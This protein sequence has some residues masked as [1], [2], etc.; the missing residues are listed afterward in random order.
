MS[1]MEFKADYGMRLAEEGVGSTV[2]IFFYEFRL[3]S[4]TVL[5]AGEYSTMV[6]MP[7]KGKV[8]ALSLDF[9]QVLLEEI[10]RRATSAVAQDIR[11]GIRTAPIGS[12]IDFEGHVAFGVRA[13]LGT[14]QSVQKEQF[15]PL[16][17]HEILGGA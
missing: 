4:L 13:R 1:D 5:G 2:D 11:N 10:L 15:I 16:V 14:I 9:K 8:F 6:E 17:A 12:T 3:H 7:Y